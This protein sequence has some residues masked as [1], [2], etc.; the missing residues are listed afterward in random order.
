MNWFDK[1]FRKNAEERLDD[2]EVNVND[3]RTSVVEKEVKKPKHII[4][5]NKKVEIE[6]D[7]VVL[8]TD[9]SGLT[10]PNGN[11]IKRNERYP[12]MIC[13]HWDACLNTRQMYNVTLERGLSVHF[14]I[15]NDGTIYQFLDTKHIAYHAR[16]IN[17]KSIGI[18]IANPVKLRYN[19]RN[20]KKGLPERNIIAND[21]IHGKP[22]GPYL[23]YYP[24][25][26]NALEA[27]IKVLSKE[28][29]IPLQAPMKN[30]KLVRGVDSRVKSEVFRGLVGH[31]HV[32]EDKIDPGKLPL[33]EIVK[34][35]KEGDK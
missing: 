22:T 31:Y 12:K 32:N 9:I 13:A 25:Q 7:D 23:Y 11:Y 5:N 14:G 30:G 27:L 34:R 35:I 29:K 21:K 24:A 16:G 17:R 20:R 10:Y 18:E 3:F 6:W 2:L 1:L 26:L 33:D 28:C 19:K 4:I 8:Y 15:D